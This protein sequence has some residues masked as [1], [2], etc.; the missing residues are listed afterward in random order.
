M[1]PKMIT[2]GTIISLMCDGIHQQDIGVSNGVRQYINTIL[3]PSPLK[4]TPIL[5]FVVHGRYSFYR[6]SP[7]AS[8]PLKTLPTKKYG[9]T[10]NLSAEMQLI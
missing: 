6:I 4:S 8:P 10:I 9:N 7:T 2:V 5:P 1:Y 3:A